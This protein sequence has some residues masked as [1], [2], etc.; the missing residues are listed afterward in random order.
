MTQV[1]FVGLGIM[2]LPMARHILAK[3]FALHVHNRTAAKAET[4]VAA[5][6][7][8]H[9]T[10]AA[11]AAAADVVICM[12]TDAPDVQAVVAG[13]EGILQGLRSA[14]V[15]VNM[16]T[17]APQSEQALAPL[18][19]TRG[20]IYLDAPVSGGDVGARAGTLA[21][22][23][24][25]DAAALERVRPVLACMGTKITHCGPVGAGQATKL[26]NQILVG[27]NLLATCE[28][29]QFAR[30]MG[31]DPQTMIDAV[32]GGAAGSW[33]LK[34]LGPRLARGDV[35]PGFMIDL[36]QK[37]LRAVMQSAGASR[38]PLLG[39]ALVQ[40]LFSSAQAHGDGAEGTQ[41]LIRVLERL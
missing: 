26:C 14:A 5:G 25:G 38:V 22:M 33:Q 21:I 13:S 18:V 41:A 37:D 40:Q 35:A 12:V 29:V 10:P 24:G 9:P 30:K 2:G 32:S 31:L 8:Q 11:V 34:E 4:L 15:V 3:G 39:T 36:M 27:M 20:G 23:V 16:S 19:H 28:A 7:T 17:V 6:A 1:G